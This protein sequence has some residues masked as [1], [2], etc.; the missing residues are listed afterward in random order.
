MQ[1]GNVKLNQ[2]LGVLLAVLCVVIVFLLY[3]RQTY[4]INQDINDSIN[5]ETIDGQQNTQTENQINNEIKNTEET[6]SQT[7][8]ENEVIITIQKPM[9]ETKTQTG[10]GGIGCFYPDPNTP[11]NDNPPTHVTFNGHF[12]SN[13]KETTTWFEYW[14]NTNTNAEVE[15]VSTIKQVHAESSGDVSQYITNLDRGYMYSFRL[16]AENARGI[17]YGNTITFGIPIP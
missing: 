2:I 16:V 3:K 6:N 15:K 11:C 1:N 9:A 10:L 17:S 13:D 5:F 8:V 12:E 7:N 4:D 14:R